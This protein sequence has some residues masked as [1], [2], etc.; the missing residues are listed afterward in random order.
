MI[1]LAAVTGWLNTWLTPL[2]LIGLGALLG[3]AL[4]LVAWLLV[5]LVSREGGGLVPEVVSEGPLFPIF[6]VVAGAAFFGLVGWLLIRDRSEIVESLTRL[7]F[8]GEQALIVS[9]PAAADEMSEPEPVS[10]RVPFRGDELERLEITSNES[11]SIA[12]PAAEGEEPELR[13]EVLGGDDTTTWRPS[14]ETVN[15]LSGLS[16]D[17]LQLT[18]QGTEDARV[19]MT[20]LTAAQHPEVITV[21]ITAAGVFLIFLAYMLLRWLFP[22]VSAVALTTA[23]SE[24]YQPLTIILLML[25][26]ALLFVFMWIPYHT[27]GEDIKVLKDTGLTLIMVFCILQA[28]WAA[29][30]SVAEEIEGRTALTLLSKPIRRSEFVMGKFLGIAWTSLAMFLILGTFLLIVVGYKPIY[31]ARETA[32]TAPIWAACHLEIVQTVPGLVLAFL[33]TLVFIAISVAIA[34]R[35]PLLANVVICFS[36]YALGHLTPLIVQSSMGK[37]EIVAFVGNLIA[38]VL[39]VLDHF[40]IQAAVAAGV[41]VPMVYLGTAAIYSLLYCTAALILAL[42]LFEDRDLA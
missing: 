31:D 39:P 27:F 7:P 19:E 24:M 9:V 35:L 36:I 29:S 8:V 13:I 40:N 3:L 42:V 10:V 34:T 4:L 16:F 23:K 41:E 12:T 37:F 21:V 32:Q 15:P 17:S 14:S 28:V 11:L 20:V 26:L 6:T 22:K 2:W 25:G 30:D 5:C 33:E 1:F 18:N 38:V